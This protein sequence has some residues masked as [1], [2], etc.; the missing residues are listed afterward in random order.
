MLFFVRTAVKIDVLLM[1]N[2]DS[3]ELMLLNMNQLY[4]FPWMPFHYGSS[5]QWCRET[6]AV[7]Y[8]SVDPAL[9]F[10]YCMHRRNGGNHN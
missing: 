5:A 7:R 3:D 2:S 8:H 10:R 1:L 6:G 4:F 9:F